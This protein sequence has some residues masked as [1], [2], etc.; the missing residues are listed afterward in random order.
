VVFFDVIFIVQHYLLYPERRDRGK[1]VAAEQAEPFLGPSD[2]PESA[3][4]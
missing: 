2:K 3:Q 4:V 1:S